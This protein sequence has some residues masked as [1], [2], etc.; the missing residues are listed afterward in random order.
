MLSC[1]E[2]RLSLFFAPFYAQFGR[3]EVK[4]DSTCWECDLMVTFQP[5]F[6]TSHCKSEKCLVPGVTVRAC[7][8]EK[9]H[10]VILEYDETKYFATFMQ[11][12]FLKIPL[13]QDINVF[14]HRW[15]ERIWIP[16]LLK[17]QDSPWFKLAPQQL[18]ETSHSSSSPSPLY[19]PSVNDV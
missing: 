7:W 18:W 17:K 12:I 10:A 16:G 19:V 2:R 4:G 8:R 13:N 3:S 6:Q 15:L 14:I 5:S 1:C 11:C 9:I